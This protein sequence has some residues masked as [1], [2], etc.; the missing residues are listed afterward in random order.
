MT[1]THKETKQCKAAHPVQYLI[2]QL[3]LNSQKWCFLFLYHSNANN[4][5]I[6]I[7][8]K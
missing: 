7:D 3:A 8:N 2:N 1:D 5:F 4:M 6:H